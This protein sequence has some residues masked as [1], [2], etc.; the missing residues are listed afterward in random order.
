VKT[1]GSPREP[2]SGTGQV[3]MQFSIS[4]DGR[5]LVYSDAYIDT[6]IARV[7][8]AQADM[9]R[10]LHGETFIASTQ[11]D[12]SPQ[13]SPDGRKIAFASARSGHFEIWVAD[14]EGSNPTQLTFWNRYTGTPR[15]SPGGDEIA[16]DSQE[17]K[18]T[19]I[20]AIGVNSG[21]T[22]KITAGAGRNF[23]PSW[24]RDG[25]WI[26]FVS[27]RR[28]GFQVW[29]ALAHPPDDTEYAMQV[30]KHGG[31]AGWESFDGKRFYY[32][33]AKAADLSCIWMVAADG[34][35]ES[36]VICPVSSW[37]Y[38]A[39]FP[40]GIYYAP[41]TISQIWFFRFADTEARHVFDLKAGAGGGFA[42]SPDRKWLLIT[43]TDLRRGD[44]YLID[45]LN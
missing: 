27:D 36:E 1:D 28:D 44:L 21:Q 25:K 4:R 45:N 38:M 26:Y 16:A 30:T 42:I 2:L 11:W 35:A 20:Y 17:G 43:L 18:R 34:V 39:M 23:I 14:A 37:M 3:G 15:W 7:S 13:Y 10:P 41:R 32:A 22:R 6:D 12:G 19:D 33:K 5:R 31:F 8:L 40:D 29:K 9:E 24:S